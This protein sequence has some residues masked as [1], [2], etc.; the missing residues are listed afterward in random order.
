MTEPSE[1]RVKTP[2]EMIDYQNGEADCTILAVE[3]ATGME[4]SDSDVGTPR[5]N[6]L[7][8]LDYNRMVWSP[9]NGGGLD[10]TTAA[11]ITLAN[12]ISAL[13]L[14][15]DVQSRKMEE[16]LAAIEQGGPVTNQ[17]D[18]TQREYHLDYLRKWMETIVTSVCLAH[19]TATDV[20]LLLEDFQRRLR[21]A[22]QQPYESESESEPASPDIMSPIRAAPPP[23]FHTHHPAPG[24]AESCSCCA[25]S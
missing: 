11:K 20:S 10:K 6:P 17:D 4:L 8:V 19:P 9:A 14:E 5:Q 16:R 3:D 7:S 18:D 2:E 12:E 13:R 22:V 25:I 1:I 21:S 15:Y 23:S 24:D